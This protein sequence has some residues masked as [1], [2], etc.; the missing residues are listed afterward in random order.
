MDRASDRAS[1]QAEQT[2]ATVCVILYACIRRACR[3]HQRG[4]PEVDAPLTLPDASLT[5]PVCSRPRAETPRSPFDRRR[6][7]HPSRIFSEGWWSCVHCNQIL[8][9]PAPEAE[10]EAEAE[11]EDEEAS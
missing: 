1:E 2:F 3:F 9:G 5:L 7:E 10:A 6:C 11:A 8:L 4:Q